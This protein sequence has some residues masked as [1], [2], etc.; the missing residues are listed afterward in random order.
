MLLI[1][2]GFVY[3]LFC[4]F[5]PFAAVG[6]YAYSFFFGDIFYCA[7]NMCCYYHFWQLLKKETENKK[8]PSF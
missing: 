3:I 1:F 7:T 4:Y 6:H 2:V 8:S 5:L